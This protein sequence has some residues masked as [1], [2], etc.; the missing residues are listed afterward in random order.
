MDVEKVEGL[1]EKSEIYLAEVVDNALKESWNDINKR[2]ELTR[3]L[4]QKVENLS[5]NG[6]M[7]LES[8]SYEDSLKNYDQIVSLIQGYS[9]QI[10][11]KV[12]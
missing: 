10:K 3:D 12:S 4:I 1:I 6:F 9:K 11:G 5:K 2:V 8:K 7:A